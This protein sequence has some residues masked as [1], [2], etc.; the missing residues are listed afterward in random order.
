MLITHGLLISMTEPNQVI[1]DG[2]VLVQGGVIADL[3]TTADLLAHHG[4]TE[5]EV[6]NCRNLQSKIQNPKSRMRCAG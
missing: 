1:E 5:T 3:G 6:I 2:A 4:S